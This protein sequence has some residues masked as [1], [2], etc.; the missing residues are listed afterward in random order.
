MRGK[1]GL[2]LVSFSTPS[3]ITIRKKFLFTKRAVVSPNFKTKDTPQKIS[4]LMCKQSRVILFTIDAVV[5][6]M[7][8]NTAG[9][10]LIS[11]GQND[12]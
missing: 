9:R 3:L 1:P 10:L 12:F 5:F 11:Y 6:S 2:T 4:N 7:R 8:F